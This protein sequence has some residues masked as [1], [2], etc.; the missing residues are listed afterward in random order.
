V[1]FSC[2]QFQVKQSKSAMKIS[3]DSM[4][5]GSWTP[6]E[7][8]PYN[9]LDI[10]SGT[11]IIALM[12]AQRSYAETIDAIEIDDNSYQECVENFENSPW[13]DRLF[14]FHAS[15]D[16]FLEEEEELE[17]YDLIVSNPP[18]YTEDLPHNISTKH[19]AKFEASLPFESLINGVAKILSPLGVFTVIIPY[20][21]IDNF[22]NLAQENQFFPFKI[23][24]VKGNENAVFKRSLIAF[25]RTQKDCFT[26]ELTLEI[27]RH[28]YT[29]AYKNLTKDFYL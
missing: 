26:D 23:T 12:L 17:E 9:I 21:E 6:I 29:E 14:C 28:Q 3:T 10:G 1:V 25:S 8:N 15:W 7:N 27:K 18:F 5:L 4:L 19:L 2:K 22:I 11:G 16:E 20:K 13:N 24:H